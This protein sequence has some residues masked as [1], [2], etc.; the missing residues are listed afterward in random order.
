MDALAQAVQDAAGTIETINLEKEDHP[1]WKFK[2]YFSTRYK[3]V[4][5][6]QKYQLFRMTRDKPGQVELHLLSRYG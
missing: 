4:T 3:K 1:F 6:I 2:D 5:D